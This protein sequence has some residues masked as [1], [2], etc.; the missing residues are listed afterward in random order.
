[1]PSF[2]KAS[3]IAISGGHF[4]EIHGSVYLGQN[5]DAEG[6]SNPRR[7]VLSWRLMYCIS[8][9]LNSI[10]KIAEKD[11]T[12]NEYS[13]TEGTLKLPTFTKDEAPHI[14]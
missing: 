2:E 6:E 11:G 5:P 14:H 3:N 13:L 4:S 12:F 7:F 9:A 8:S 1:M 10:R